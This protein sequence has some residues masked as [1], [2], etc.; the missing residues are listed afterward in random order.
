MDEQTAQ[1]L[2]G[3]LRNAHQ[4]LAIAAGELSRDETN[5]GGKA[6]AVLELRPVAVCSHDSCG[7]FRDN[8]LDLRDALT[9]LVLVEDSINLFVEQANAAVEI[10]EEIVKSVI[11]PGR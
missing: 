4:H 3:A 9:C 10:A 6:P 5:P 11:A 2:V 1:V 7:G 8:A